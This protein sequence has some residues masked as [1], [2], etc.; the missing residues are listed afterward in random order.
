MKE[1][2]A[3]MPAHLMHQATESKRKNTLQ[4][5]DFL[6]LL[7]TQLKNQD[8]LNPK[9][10]EQF[11]TQLAQFSSLEQLSNIGKGI[12][13]L[14]GGM[15]SEEKLQALGMIGK[16]VKASGNKVELLHGKEVSLEYLP[17][18]EIGIRFGAGTF[19]SRKKNPS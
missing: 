12:D 10:H 18:K 11:A 9:D 5:D 1:L 4:K 13:K 19:R 8:P 15:S 3:A 16:E 2:S 17:D 14:Q 6:R 7:M